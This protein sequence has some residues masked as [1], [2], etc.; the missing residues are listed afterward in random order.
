LSVVSST[1]QR[2]LPKWWWKLLSFFLLLFTHFQRV[3]FFTKKDCAPVSPWN[4]SDSP[5]KN[6]LFLFKK[7]SGRCASNIWVRL[8]LI[9]NRGVVVVTIFFFLF[10]VRYIYK[11]TFDR[12]I[13]TQYNKKRLFSFIF[14]LP[15]E[16]LPPFVAVEPVA[17]Y[18]CYP[19][20]N[21]P[22]LRAFS[23]L[24]LEF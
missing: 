24:G 23:P 7:S 13:Q 22:I 19:F 3:F 18:C 2:R 12:T 16:C 6:V 1:A 11:V 10:S 4:G 21:F 9:S 17:S 15:F 8:S 14:F 20:L 5:E